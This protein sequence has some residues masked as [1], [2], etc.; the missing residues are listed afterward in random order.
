MGEDILLF[1]F[2]AERGS[3]GG[4]GGEGGRGKGEG[5]DYIFGA[6]TW[7]VLGMGMAGCGYWGWRGGIVY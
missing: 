5:V 2:W 1:L 4:T 7:W 3:E 6:V